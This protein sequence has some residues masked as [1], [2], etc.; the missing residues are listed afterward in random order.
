MR[1]E[2]IVPSR[3]LGKRSGHSSALQWAAEAVH[4]DGKGKIPAMAH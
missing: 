3:S 4:S 1:Q 2:S